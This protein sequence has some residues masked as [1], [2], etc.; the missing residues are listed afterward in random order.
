MNTM[1]IILGSIIGVGCG[2][3]LFLVLDYRSDIK[4]EQ[5]MSFSQFRSLY[6]V[7]PEKWYVRYCVTTR[8]FYG[9]TPIYMKSYFDYLRLRC[10]A[11]KMMVNKQNKALMEERAR[12]LKEW[13]QD[14]N[15]FHEEGCDL[16]KE[17]TYTTTG[18]VK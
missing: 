14:I 6:L 3:Y 2:V 18:R 8:A 15:K 16:L 12:L 7:A 13:Q 17:F 1:A 4:D 5:T 9:D 11:K 10:F